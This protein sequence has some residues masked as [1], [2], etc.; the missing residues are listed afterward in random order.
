MADDHQPIPIPFITD[1]SLC[2][3]LNQIENQLADWE[4]AIPCMR[5]HIAGLRQQLEPRSPAVASET[6]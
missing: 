3:E 5:R 2:R 1:D 4:A 6:A